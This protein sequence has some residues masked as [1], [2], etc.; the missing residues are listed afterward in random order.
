MKERQHDAHVVAYDNMLVNEV[1]IPADA[2]LTV[3]GEGFGE[4]IPREPYV[5]TYVIAKEG[6]AEN[7][8]WGCQD[9]LGPDEWGPLSLAYHYGREDVTARAEPEPDGFWMPYERAWELEKQ[10]EQA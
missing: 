9:I 8:Y 2:H 10:D 6:V 4:D 5:N 1:V 7:L 3:E